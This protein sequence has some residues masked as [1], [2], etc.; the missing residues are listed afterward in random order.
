MLSKCANPSCSATFRFLHEG[1]LFHVEIASTLQEGTVALE[2]FWLCTECS[3]KL[4]VVS[5]S[6][7][8]VVTPRQPRSKK[9]EIPARPWS[10]LDSPRR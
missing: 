8:A 7:G 4:T 1:T 6:A 5:D 3:R 9:S 2:R 10:R